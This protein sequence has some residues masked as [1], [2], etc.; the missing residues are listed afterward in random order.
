MCLAS[1]IQRAQDKVDCRLVEWLTRPTELTTPAINNTR[2]FRMCLDTWSLF[3]L[4]SDFYYLDLE[5]Y[6]D[7]IGLDLLHCTAGTFP[8][9]YTTLTLPISNP[10]QPRSKARKGQKICYE[11]SSSNR[12]NTKSFRM[13]AVLIAVCKLRLSLYPC[14][15]PQRYFHNCAVVF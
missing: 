12:H 14:T 2:S 9:D 3:E 5:A 11:L 7:T 15:P 13:L 8:F 4:N 6:S 1:R 10:S